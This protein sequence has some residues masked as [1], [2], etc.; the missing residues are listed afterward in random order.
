MLVSPL[1][2]L[3][4]MMPK[5]LGQE[6]SYFCHSVFWG[7]KLR[8][9]SIANSIQP[10]NFR[11]FKLWAI[12]FSAMNG[13]VTAKLTSHFK[14]LKLSVKIMH[15]AQLAF[16]IFSEGYLY[17]CLYKKQ[18]M[19]TEIIE[20]NFTP[21]PSQDEEEKCLICY[22]TS[23]DDIHTLPANSPIFYVQGKRVNQPRLMGT[24]CRCVGSIFHSVHLGCMANWLTQNTTRKECP[25]RGSLDLKSSVWKKIRPIVPSLTALVTSYWFFSAYLKYSK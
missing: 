4:K 18:G 23:Y 16:A 1:Y 11:N 6:Y 20:V 19:K 21:L 3:H 5:K 2:F 24:V 8:F 12:F 13:I 15:L 10:Q 25:L 9:L 22:E 7:A 17:H 14:D